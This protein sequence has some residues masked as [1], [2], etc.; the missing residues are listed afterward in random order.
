MSERARAPAATTAAALA[1]FRVRCFLLV[2]RI[3]APFFVRI[4]ERPSAV[5]CDLVYALGFG[6][7]KG[8]SAVK[9]GI[10]TAL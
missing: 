8:A 5:P 3:T 10:V 9:R 4:V 7:G 6:G 2:L 1:A